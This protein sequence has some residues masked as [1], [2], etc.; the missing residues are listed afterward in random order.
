MTAQRKTLELSG[1]QELKLI[2]ALADTY[3]SIQKERVRASNRIESMLKDMDETEV[4]RQVVMEKIKQLEE[5]EKAIIKDI[6]PHLKKIAVYN[7]FLS[8]VKGIGEV[9]TTKLLAL[10]LKP[11]LNLTSWNAYFGLVPTYYL[12][13]CEKGHR[14]MYPKVP[15]GCPVEIG[16]P[17]NRKKCGAN[18]SHTEFKEGAPR[19]MRGYKPFWNPKARALY[20]LIAQNFIRVGERGFYGRYFRQ[21]KQRYE[22][23]EDLKNAPKIK[24]NAMAM[25]ST[26]KL[27]LSHYYQAFHELAGLPYRLPYQFEYLKH[28]NFID[29]KDV[30]RQG[31]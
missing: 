1:N 27:F 30:I 16:D 2:R 28:T 9:F 31:G 13:E 12:C 23:R 17:K 8:R 19:R 26:F 5:I 14:F 6:R 10:P 3:M 11:G 18:I 20:F 15:S 25:R 4:I 29:W 22:Q 21:V 24:I 7:E